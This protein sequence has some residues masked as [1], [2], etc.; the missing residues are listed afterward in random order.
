MVCHT[1]RRH[2][3]QVNMALGMDLKA[4]APSACTVQTVANPRSN[5]LLQVLWNPFQRAMQK[6]EQLLP[7][8]DPALYIAA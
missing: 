5:S 2:E 3:K 8:P 7:T 1:M 6:G 4:G